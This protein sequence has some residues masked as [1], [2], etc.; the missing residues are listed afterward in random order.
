MKIAKESLDARTLRW[1]GLVLGLGLL[2]AFVAPAKPANAE[3]D[4]GPRRGPPPA[5]F[6]ACKGKKADD[7]CEVT[8]HERKMNGKCATPPE[9]TA[10]ACRPE[11]GPRPPR[12]PHA[13]AQ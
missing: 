9:G 11:R 7:A 12:P 8:F 10:L 2:A 3:P 13:Q 5:A 1:G 6:D 4:H